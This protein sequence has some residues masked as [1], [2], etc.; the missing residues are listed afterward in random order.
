M[1]CSLVRLVLFLGLLPLLFIIP[2]SV[3][4]QNS[5]TGIPPNE[6]RTLNKPL[7]NVKLV[8]HTGKVFNIYELRGKPLIISPIYT[9][10]QSAC[11][12]I[13]DSLKSAIYKL[14]TPG[15]DFFV[16]SFTFDP[17]DKIDDLKKFRIEKNIYDDGWLT[18]KAYSKEDLF[19]LVDAL[20]FRFMTVYETRDFIHPNLVAFISSDL[21]LK[22]YVYGVVFKEEDLEKAL[23]YTKGEVSIAEYLRPYIFFISLV[24]II[25]ISLFILVKLFSRSSQKIKAAKYL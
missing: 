25:A 1:R 10:C 4:A 18:V 7:P 21:V 5:G 15:K 2:T 24:G 12:L 8:D 9:H 20:D 13:T 17:E 23:R 6:S 3:K 14:G 11:P 19:K 22:K 16:V